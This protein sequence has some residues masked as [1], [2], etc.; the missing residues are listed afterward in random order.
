ML[1]L[2]HVEI[3]FSI[4]LFFTDD[5]RTVRLEE[6][7]F[8]Q[9]EMLKDQTLTIETQQNQLDILND[10][11]NEQAN[12]IRHQNEILS[13]QSATIQFLKNDIITSM[14]CKATDQSKP[15]REN[16][17]K[18]YLNQATVVVLQTKTRRTTKTKIQMYRQVSKHFWVYLH[19]S[20]DNKIQIFYSN[21][22]NWSIG[23]LI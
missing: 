18:R 20:L 9:Q 8:H 7:M 5:M 1:F 21:Y 12:I 16:L 17:F 13:A 6:M 23:R 19:P 4:W 11:F 22:F 10:R 14:P 2:C 15:T 3:N